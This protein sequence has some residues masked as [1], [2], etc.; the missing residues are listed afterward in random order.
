MRVVSSGGVGILSRR[1]VIDLKSE[2]ED[3]F[4][5]FFGDID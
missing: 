2:V 3:E 4:I 1:V 5:L